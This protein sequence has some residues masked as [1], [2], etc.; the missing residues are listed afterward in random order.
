MSTTSKSP[1]RVL[2]AAYAVAKDALPDY[3]HRFS[4][5]KFTQ[6]QLLACLVLK[7]FFKTDY[8]GI[9]AILADSPE[10]V[11]AI[12]LEGVPHFT[13]L[14][15]AAARLTRTAHVNRLLDAA[16]RLAQG[17]KTMKRRV[18]LAAMDGTGFESRHISRYFIKRRERGGHPLYQTTTYRRYPKLGAVCDCFSHMILSVV[19]GRGPSPDS[20]HYQRALT[21]A[22]GRIPIDVLLADAGYDSEQAHVFA[23]ETHGV[24]AIIPPKK[25]RPTRK[26]PS[27]QYRRRMARRFDRSTYGQRWQVE[28]A[29]SMMKRCLGS[30]LRARSYWSQ[31][32]ET[33][34]RVITHNVM[35]LYVQGGFLRSSGVPFSRP[36]RGGHHWLLR[37]WPIQGLVKSSSNDP[38]D[39]NQ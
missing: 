9:E 11:R 30:S 1:R 12:Q 21:D 28:T 19:P 10:L 29:F 16:I 14:Q 33:M 13:T 15:K 7:E 26:L 8:R 25:G 4:P 23:R 35:I 5:K 3:A 34:L 22:V 27:G 31:C 38:F 18:R 37:W 36:V 6:P 17:T 39:N 32:R 2:L 24:R 20:L